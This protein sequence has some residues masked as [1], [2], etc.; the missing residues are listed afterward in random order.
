V[1]WIQRIQKVC[2]QKSFQSQL[3]TMW[4]FS[5]S[6][7]WV[8]R[9]LSPGMWRHV[10]LYIIANISKEWEISYPEDGASTFIQTPVMTFQTRW[11]NTFQPITCHLFKIHF[12]FEVFC[13][14]CYEELCLV[15]NLQNLQRLPPTLQFLRSQ[16]TAQW[17]LY[18]ELNNSL[19]C[20]P[21]TFL[22]LLNA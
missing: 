21:I 18:W 16:V 1:L 8:W 11:L 15:W 10:M 5:F 13:L 17:K 7:Q 3:S 9:L 6:R 12:I 2:Q 4:H 14:Q 19:S 20:I 22:S